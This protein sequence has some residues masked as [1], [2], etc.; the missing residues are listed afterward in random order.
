MADGSYH[1]STPLWIRTEAAGKTAAGAKEEPVEYKV[2][3]SREDGGAALITVEGKAS[4]TP[5]AE[6]E[7]RP[8]S[9]QTSS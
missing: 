7:V 5:P 8:A 9:G 1:I 6:A 3:V 2:L 4:V